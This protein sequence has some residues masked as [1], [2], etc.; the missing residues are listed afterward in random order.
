MNL[1]TPPQNEQDNHIIRSKFSYAKL[2]TN[3]DASK[4]AT[5]I[6]IEV[7][8]E[9][10]IKD[11]RKLKD[12]KLQTFGGYSRI[13]VLQ[14]FEKSII[15][16]N[17]DKAVYWGAQL[18][19]SGL[20]HIVW[21]KLISISEKYINTNNP[22]LPE[23]I[24][25]RSKSFYHNIN[26]NSNTKLKAEGILLTRNFTEFRNWIVEL[27]VILATSRKHK[28]DTLPSIKKQDFIIET[29]K[30]RLEAT[31]TNLTDKIL[32]E[33]D[34]TE[35]RIAAN[36]M[37]FHIYH[38]NLGKTLYW[39]AWMNEWE[40]MNTKKYGKF[41]VG[42]RAQSDIDSKFYR[43]ISWLFWDIIN[44]VKRLLHSQQ[45]L[46]NTNGYELEQID[47][48]WN[49]YKI[50][51]TPGQNTRKMPLIIWS[52][53]Y[54]T[55]PCDWSIRLIEKEM[56]VFQAIMNINIIYKTLK[57]QEHNDNKEQLQNYNVVIQNNYDYSKTANS[58]I[59]SQQPKKT[60][61]SSNPISSSKQNKTKSTAN[62][63]TLT[64]DKFNT[65]N[66]LDKYLI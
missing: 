14:A 28:L 42:I 57:L 58:T 55:T 9:V 21:D 7:P 10:M 18:V 47:A 15:N 53:K 38:K 50:N 34:P 40:K 56:L 36:E 32:K 17:I 65:L 33:D 13:Q 29:V 6:H 23:F 4:D 20:I 49:L 31:D 48:L 19:C 1:R 25:H 35:I 39:I 37:A 52:V 5:F 24:L 64:L 51:Y 26:L 54:I 41:E 63:N 59:I 45:R 66:K 61:A 16:E 8:E 27:S 11:S 12:F 62:L 43:N 30:S 46:F 2:D 60:R 22:K 3:I 44:G